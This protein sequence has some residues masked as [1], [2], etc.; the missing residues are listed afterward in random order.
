MATQWQRTVIN[1]PRAYGAEER[2]AIGQA[3]CAY[4]RYRTRE[5]GLDRTNKRFS[6]YSVA[7][8]KSLNF[9]IARKSK[10]N[11]NLTQS[12]DMLDALD[13]LSHRPGQI[14]IGWERGSNENAIADGNIRGTYGQSRQIGPRRDPNGITS[15]DLR[16]ILANFPLDDREASKETAA[17]IVGSGKEVALLNRIVRTTGDDE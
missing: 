1:I 13:V 11:V 9:K 4:I 14:V 8:T 2:L 12:G 6:R 16:R 15:P 7:Y 10:S 3:I 17:I 5:L